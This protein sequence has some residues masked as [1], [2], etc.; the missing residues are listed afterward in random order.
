M[1]MINKEIIIII[2]IADHNDINSKSSN[3]DK[4]TY[5]NNNK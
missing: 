3:K 4:N 2:V 5:I 1:I